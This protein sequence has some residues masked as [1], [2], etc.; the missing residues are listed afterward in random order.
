MIKGFLA[1]S[2]HLAPLPAAGGTGRAKRRYATIRAESDAAMNKQAVQIVAKA[3]STPVAESGKLTLGNYLEQWLSEIRSSIR[4]KTLRWYAHNVNNY[5]IP[6][7]GGMQLTKLRPGQIQEFY[8]GLLESGRVAETATG[9]PGEALPAISVRGVHSTL[10]S[11][12][13]RAMRQQLITYNP[14]AG[15]DPPKVERTEQQTLTVEEAGRLLEIS[16]STG[17]YSL[18]LA[19]LTTGMRQ[20]ELLGLTWSDIDLEEGILKVRQQLT[21]TY[22]PDGPVFGP[23]KSRRRTILICEPLKEALRERWESELIERRMPEYV[24]RLDLVWHIDSGGP[25]SERNLVTQFKR[26]LREASCPDVR[27]HDLRHTAA[28][29]MV[30]MGVPMKTVQEILGHS[31]IRVTSDMYTHLTLEAQRFAATNVGKLFAVDNKLNKS[32]PTKSNVT[33]LSEK[34][35][36]TNKNGFGVNLR[37]LVI[38]GA[39]CRT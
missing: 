18:F 1:T 6:K 35:R 9:K 15:V 7:L 33:R 24:N 5:I 29:L 26:L 39:S 30:A 32:S 11:A 8:S 36:Q 4:P 25:I 10:S 31:S 19:A 38:S 34:R 21:K 23:P 16:K 14:L 28:S 13:S 2:L 12:L 3:N 17:R 20:G 27:F 37:T 22:S